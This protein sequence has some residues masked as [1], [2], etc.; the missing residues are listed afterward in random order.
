M[1][2]MIDF[3][4]FSGGSNITIVRP[5]LLPGGGSYSLVFP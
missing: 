4:A 3:R 5:T 2:Q 1:P